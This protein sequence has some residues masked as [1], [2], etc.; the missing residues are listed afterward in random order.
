MHQDV[1]RNWSYVKGSWKEG[2]PGGNDSF[3]GWRV[4]GN[5]NCDYNVGDVIDLVLNSGAYMQFYTF[6]KLCS[7]ASKSY[8][9]T[10]QA[11]D[12]RYSMKIPKGCYHL[13]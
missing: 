3:E 6:S 2:S 9:A 11:S 7:V 4:C 12:I 8:A 13:H 10:I 1:S 5:L